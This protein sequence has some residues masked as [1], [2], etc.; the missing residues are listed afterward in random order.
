MPLAVL[1]GDLSLSHC[2]PEAP[3]R[4]TSQ[5]NVRFHNTLVVV[6]GDNYEPHPGPCSIIPTHT[7]KTVLGAGSPT[8]FINN[9]RIYRDGDPLNCGDAAKVQSHIDVFIN[10]LG[11]IP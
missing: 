4:A 7:P 8:V 6:E 5:T 1:H 10:G 11:A 9:K 2:W 3:A